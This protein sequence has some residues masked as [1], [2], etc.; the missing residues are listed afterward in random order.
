MHIVLLLRICPLVR[1]KDALEKK[2]N[3]Y[4]DLLQVLVDFIKILD[5]IQEV[6][7]LILQGAGSFGLKQNSEIILRM[8]PLCDLKAADWRAG[9]CIK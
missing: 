1:R 2:E 5:A 9:Q 6:E 3:C 4:E 7:K 8:F